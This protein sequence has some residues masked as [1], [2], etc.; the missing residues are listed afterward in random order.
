MRTN[1]ARSARTKPQRLTYREIR[2]RY[3]QEWVVVVDVDTMSE[4]DH[5]LCSAIVVGHRK[6][7]A[8]ASADLRA[9]F[10]RYEEVG[11]FWTGM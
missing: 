10:R 4:R 1:T 2:E 7:R 5:E 11:C 8:D 6:Q 9:A 3:P